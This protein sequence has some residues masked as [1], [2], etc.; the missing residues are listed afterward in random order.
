MFFYQWVGADDRVQ[1]CWDAAA[2]KC[3]EQ[4][5]TLFRLEDEK[6][7]SIKH[8]DRPLCP[9]GFRMHRDWL[10]HAGPSP[11]GSTCRREMP[12]MSLCRPTCWLKPTSAGGVARCTWLCHVSGRQGCSF[13]RTSSIWAYTYICACIICNSAIHV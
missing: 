8:W 6:L 7:G 10:L 1:C 5:L 12:P 13:P 9:W 3:W 2:R 4:I 11:H